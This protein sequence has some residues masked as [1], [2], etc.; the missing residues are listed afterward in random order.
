MFTSKVLTLLGPIN[1]PL[2]TALSPQAI[3]LGVLYNSFPGVPAPAPASSP[4]SAT[5][6]GALGGL[7]SALAMGLAY[8]LDV[9]RAR[10]HHNSVGE[11]LPPF[12]HLD[13]DFVVEEG[14]RVL[15]R[16]QTCGT[17]LLEAHSALLLCVM[18]EAGLF[19]VCL[20]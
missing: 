8:P 15:A 10:A 14:L 17:D 20:S 1:Y 12:P 13:C 4:N 3:V 9:Y 18:A 11:C 19:E 7:A 5:L 2:F 16:V 6:D